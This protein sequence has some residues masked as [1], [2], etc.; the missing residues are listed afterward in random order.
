M[1]FFC[2]ECISLWIKH[3]K[4]QHSKQQYSKQQHS[5]QQQLQQ[6][7]QKQQ[8]HIP[9]SMKKYN[10]KYNNMLMSHEGFCGLAHLY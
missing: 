4:K 6:Q 10:G 9:E 7:Q 5:K 1:S 8:N 3:S 2:F